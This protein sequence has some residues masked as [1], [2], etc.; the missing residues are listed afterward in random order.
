MPPLWCLATEAL[1]PSAKTTCIRRVALCSRDLAQLWRGMEEEFTINLAVPAAKAPAP[2][3]PKRPRNAPSQPVT[4]SSWSRSFQATAPAPAAPEPPQVAASPR[5]RVVSE[6]RRDG[7]P[8]KRAK[9][10]TLDEFGKDAPATNHQ[11]TRRNPTRVGPQRVSMAVAGDSA[12]LVAAR[13]SSKTST[14]LWKPGKTFTSLGL[15][16]SLISRLEASPTETRRELP[17]WERRGLGLKAPTNVQRVAVPAFGRGRDVLVRAETGSG[18]TLGY[19]LPVVDGLLREALSAEAA[20]KTMSREGGTR[21]VVL[22]PTRELAGQIEE[23]ANRLCEPYPWLVVGSVT[24]G[25]KRKAEK[26]RLRKGVTLLIATPGRLVDH[27][28]KTKSLIFGGLTR[29]RWLILDEA[30][31]LL[32]LG[33]EK[34]I[35]A[36]VSA[37]HKAKD[38]AVQ[39]RREIMAASE[40]GAPVE[41][42]EEP[43][44]PGARRW[45][46]G[47]YSATLSAAVKKLAG[48]TLSNPVFVDGDTGVITDTETGE[49]VSL[50]DVA[51]ESTK[52]FHIPRQLEQ[53]AVPC[54]T[55]WRLVSLLGTIRYFLVPKGTATGSGKLIV[56]CATC[57]A[58]DYLK[59]L[60]GRVW[61]AL[62][63]GSTAAEPVAASVKDGISPF[64]GASSLSP[65]PM[66]CTLE[67]LH[68]NMPQ[69]ERAG[70]LSRFA[71]AKA[72]V[73]LATDV[74][75]RGLD[76]PD[77]DAVVQLDLPETPAEYAHRIGRTARSGHVGR[78]IVFL[79]PHEMPLIDALEKHGMRLVKQSNV[80]LLRSLK[81]APLP[82]A[83]LDLSDSHDPRVR[84]L[85]GANETLGDDDDAGSRSVEMPAVRWQVLLEELA[86]KD[87]A[88]TPLAVK[89]YFAHIKAY[90]CFGKE[91]KGFLFPRALHLGHLAKSFALLEPP[92]KLDARTAE[93]DPRAAL[94]K[95]QPQQ[96][97]RF[98]KPRVSAEFDA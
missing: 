5:P 59:Q 61:T 83:L 17:A 30:D 73:L 53:F 14:H 13:S 71:A 69:A 29:L 21:C 42:M 41:E 25:E 96:R 4:T 36:V 95:K 63:T 76:L 49:K 70:A 93:P 39:K 81:G 40:G 52:E 26:A 11:G 67:G 7:P 55:K 84:V 12:R 77:V 48:V 37:V 54:P 47:L 92:S 44:A 33:F 86:S 56:F 16:D 87:A 32:D 22:A 6:R 90:A 2:R 24:G 62:T 65:L 19:L 88:L 51:S 10:P 98:P 78:A 79:A 85:R 97:K 82:T 46:V 3:A 58:V 72:G 31:R 1:C 91:F 74:A 27:L 80:P 23:V 89:A 38:H 45:L 57:D 18:K 66:S 68:G 35:Q 60:L 9:G 34:Q 64:T 28:E 94:K 75:A 20:G 43:D 8:P 50:D 15:C